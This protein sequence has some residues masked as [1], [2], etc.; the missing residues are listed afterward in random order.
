MRM[1]TPS[2]QWK[3]FQ[4]CCFCHWWTHTLV[5]CKPYA[6]ICISFLTPASGPTAIMETL[7]R[8]MNENPRKNSTP[9]LLACLQNKI[10]V[11]LLGSQKITNELYKNKTIYYWDTKDK[12]RML[13]SRPYSGPNCEVTMVAGGM[14]MV[15]SMC[16]S[17]RASSLKPPGPHCQFSSWTKMVALAK[18]LM[19]HVTSCYMTFS[20]PL[21][22]HISILSE[23]L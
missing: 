11:Q 17:P 1:R 20:F 15:N 2:P 13:A 14:F 6:R 19:F 4:G 23:G 7:R 9:H 18:P 22:S 10:Y 5:L 16:R 21:L 12:V 3:V 8:R